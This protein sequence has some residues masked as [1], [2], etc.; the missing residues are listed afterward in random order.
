MTESSSF[1]FCKGGEFKIEGPVEDKD[2]AVKRGNIST[3]DAAIGFLCGMNLRKKHSD[4]TIII[5]PTEDDDR[6]KVIWKLDMELD[7]IKKYSQIV[8]DV[9]NTTSKKSQLV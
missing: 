2:I 8:F 4:G 7:D 5:E 3:F 1:F 9:K 6:E